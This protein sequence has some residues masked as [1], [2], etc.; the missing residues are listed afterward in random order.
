MPTHVPEPT[1]VPA[2]GQPPKVI[3]EYVGVV[4]TGTPTLSV[5]RMTSPAGWSEP[6][7]TPEFAE[8]TL[9]LEGAVVV[10][11]VAGSVTVRA[12]EAVLTHP[13]EQVRYSTPEGAEYVAICVPA[14][15]PDSVHRAPGS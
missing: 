7:Q 1:V 9:V 10:S 8:V 6:A 14:F 13:G 2:V 4:T 11:S 3:R 5:A 12:G 15:T